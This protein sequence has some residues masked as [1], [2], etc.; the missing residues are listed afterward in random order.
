MIQKPII[1]DNSQ[2][3]KKHRGLGGSSASVVVAGDSI[4]LTIQELYDYLANGKPLP[5]ITSNFA[6]YWKEQERFIRD[7]LT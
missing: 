1:L 2:E 4:Y 3:W 5:D 7:S 6:T